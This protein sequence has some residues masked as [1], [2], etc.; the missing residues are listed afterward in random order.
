MEKLTSVIDELSRLDSAGTC[1]AIAKIEEKGPLKN[2]RFL[3]RL[4]LLK[5]YR[6]FYFLCNETGNLP[7][8]E[9][10]QAGLR[11]AHEDEDPLLI[12]N[13]NEALVDEYLHSNDF[14]SGLM[15]SMIANDIYE[16]TGKENFSKIAYSRY[17]LGYLLFCVREYELS[18]QTTLSAIKGF[19]DHPLKKSDTLDLRYHMYGWNTIGLDY[20]KLEKY[21]SAMIALNNALWIAEQI[22]D[23]F[24]KGLINGNRGDV[25]FQLAKYDS[26]EFL[27]SLDVKGSLASSSWDNAANSLQLL[28]RIK[29]LKGNPEKALQY[30]SEAE[31]FLGRAYQDQYQENIYYAYAM[32]YEAL[33]KADSVFS[34]MKKYQRLHDKIEQNFSDERADVAQMRMEN[35]EALYKINSLIKER[36]RIALI[37]NIVVVMIVMVSI[38]GLLF[39]NKEKLWMQVRELHLREEK[40]RVEN[41]ALS[42]KDQLKTFTDRFIEKTALADR[43]Q[44]Q[45]A[46][47]ELTDAQ[48]SHIAELSQRSILTEE[49]WEDFKKLFEQVYPGFFIG[50]REKAHDITLSEQRVAALSKLKIAPKEAAALL[51]ISHASVNKARQRLRH[52]LNLEPDTDLEVYFS[53]GLS[54]KPNA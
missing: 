29:T 20:K 54:S 33:G 51:G 15:H 35:Q 19:D 6:D 13:L 30:L 2:K 44:E 1:N 26:A 7:L 45:L 24:W 47:K 40:R 27:L 37:R 42:A 28:A 10:L 9:L 50:L 23:D 12:A 11:Y 34:Y 52:R 8:I 48:V 39:Y 3:A 46:N 53:G 21:D 49:D 14:G 38:V 17:K 32:A 31:Q 16:K 43:L 36:K 25:Y 5:A 4:H 22:K 18:L 41:E